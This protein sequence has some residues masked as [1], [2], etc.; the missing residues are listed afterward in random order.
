MATWREFVAV[1]AGAVVGTGLRLTL[2]TVIPHDDGTFP[3]STLIANVL[4]AFALGALVSTVWRRPAV[5]AWLKAGLGPGLLG[6]FTTFSAMIT[7]LLAEGTLGLTDIFALY[8]VLTL[9]LGFVAGA[10]GLSLG[11]RRRRRRP[12]RPDLVNE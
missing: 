1:A 2:D 7:S 11:R 3:L 4:G 6:S 5:P 8:L 12:R 9:L 10:L